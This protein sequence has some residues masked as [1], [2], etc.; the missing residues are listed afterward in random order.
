MLDALVWINDGAYDDAL[1]CTVEALGAQ[2]CAILTWFCRVP[3]SSKRPTTGTE[4]VKRYSE[5]M[6]SVLMCANQL[7]PL[8]SLRGN[9]GAGALHLGRP[10]Q[11]LCI[12]SSACSRSLQFTTES[13]LPAQRCASLHLLAGLHRVSRRSREAKAL[14]DTTALTWHPLMHTSRLSSHSG[15][16]SL[17]NPASSACPLRLRPALRCSQ[18]STAY[19]ARQRNR[20]LQC[21][22]KVPRTYGRSVDIRFASPS[23]KA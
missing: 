20:P 18:R 15:R 13:P 19:W 16:V 2:T 1:Q 7:V 11:P 6:L 9:L 14:E 3:I 10:A 21:H 23:A 22:A 8:P 4:Q 17:H 5:Y 12:V